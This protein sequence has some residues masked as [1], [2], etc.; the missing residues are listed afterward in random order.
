MCSLQF[1]RNKCALS[2]FSSSSDLLDTDDKRYK[3]IMEPHME[4]VWS[5]NYRLE[6]RCP[7][8]RNLHFELLCEREKKPYVSEHHMLQGLLVTEC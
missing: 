2:L 6:E 5:L 4:G 1:L 8:I 3:G 7:P